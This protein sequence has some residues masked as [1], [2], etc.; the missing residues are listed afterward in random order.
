MSIS[1]RLNAATLALKRD[2]ADRPNI[3]LLPAGAIVTPVSVPRPSDLID[4]LY[5][6]CSWS[7]FYSDLLRNADRIADASA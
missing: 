4:V 3:Q 7:L 5:D 2:G 6:D 1:Y